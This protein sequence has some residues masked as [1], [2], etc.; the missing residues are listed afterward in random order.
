MVPDQTSNPSQER[1]LTTAQKLFIAHGYHGLSMRQIA[2]AAAV[3]KAGIYYYFKDK[4]ELFIAVLTRNLEHLENLIDQARQE[5]KTA[6]Q[7]ISLLT[8]K[9]LTQPPEEQA[10]MRLASQE[11]SQL[12]QT[13]RNAFVELYHQKFIG[14][15]EALVQ[16]G[17]TAGELRPLNARL[18]TWT[19]LGM[20]YP[21]LYPSSSNEGAP[22]PQAISEMLS[23]FFDGAAWPE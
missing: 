1:I 8:K 6:R 23:I 3:S 18:V 22:A 15:I 20:M 2:E 19:L 9:I 11:M 21:Y 4:E 14:R 10:V 17:I 7:R 16:A 12:N 13:A 5:E